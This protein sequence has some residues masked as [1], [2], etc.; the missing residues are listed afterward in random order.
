MNPY[1]ELEDRYYAPF[2]SKR[3]IVLVRGK[4]ARV[5]DV[6][7]KEYI[8]CVGGYGTVNVGPVSYTHLTL[9]TN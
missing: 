1:I 3:P 5:W 8:D 6:E 9:P 2:Y 4:G 7:G